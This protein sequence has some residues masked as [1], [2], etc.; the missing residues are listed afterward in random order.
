LDLKELRKPTF[1]V[2]EHS[3]LGTELQAMKDRLVR[4]AIAIEEH[5]PTRSR[6][7]R[8]A[9]KAVQA[10]NDLRS[11]MDDRI[12]TDCPGLDV[13]LLGKVYY[14]GMVN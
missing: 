3:E 9:R 7:A 2:K 5:S 6:E 14:R 12:G 1:T 4:I 8:A 10:I 13:N 11:T